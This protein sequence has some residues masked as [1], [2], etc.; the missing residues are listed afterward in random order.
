MSKY[1]KRRM[2]EMDLINEFTKDQ[3]EELLKIQIE[4]ENYEG[5][6]IIKN[7]I[8]QYDECV[9]FELFFDIDD[10]EMRDDDLYIDDD[11]EEDDE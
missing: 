4:N 10:E 8:E 7:A 5:A 11:G 1:K 3:L 9:G 2:N 6:Q